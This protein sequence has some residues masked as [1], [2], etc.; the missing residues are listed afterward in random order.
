MAKEK[1]PPTTSLAAAVVVLV[2]TTVP[3]DRDFFSELLEAEGCEV[4]LAVDGQDAFRKVV[5]KW[6]TLIVLDLDLPLLSGREFLRI[7]SEHERLT[8]I[9][10][11]V[12]SDGS[13]HPATEGVIRRPFVPEQVLAEVRRLTGFMKRTA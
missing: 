8:T 13:P 10:V 5:L 12:I 9:P 11:L 6:P 7:R 2:A 3:G 1:V 4:A